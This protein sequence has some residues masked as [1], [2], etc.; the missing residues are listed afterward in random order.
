VA[1]KDTTDTVPASKTAIS[2][3]KAAKAPADT[4]SQAAAGNLDAAIQAKVTTG[5]DKIFRVYF[6]QKQSGNL[7]LRQM[8]KDIRNYYKSFLRTQNV[9][10]EE[11]QAFDAAFSNYVKQKTTLLNQ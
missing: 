9:P 4:T 7:D 6:A 3:P 8:H 10:A 5:L 1:V 11:R 2:E